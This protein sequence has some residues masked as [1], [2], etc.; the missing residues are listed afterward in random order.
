MCDF[1]VLIDVFQLSLEMCCIVV[2]YILA[3]FKKLGVNEG[4]LR[5][6]V[7]QL[8]VWGLIIAC[9]PQLLVATEALFEACEEHNQ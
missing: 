5:L 7:H 8:N 1:I 2:W 6:Q 9:D 4:W 3:H